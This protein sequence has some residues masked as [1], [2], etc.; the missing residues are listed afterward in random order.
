MSLSLT[1]SLSFSLSLTHSLSLS[2]SLSLSPLPLA[3]CL[4]SYVVS[5]CVA[6]S[7]FLL[8]YPCLALTDRATPGQWPRDG[9][10]RHI[11]YSTQRA[12]TSRQVTPGT[13][14]PPPRAGRTS[15]LP[16]TGHRLPPHPAPAPAHAC[17]LQTSAPAQARAISAA[18]EGRGDR[19]R[20][21]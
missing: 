6:Y 16:D 17:A 14:P 9:A 20:T 5:C 7:G 15:R 11:L 13:G 4:I 3:S 21:P 8:F 19:L 2:L 18:V 12:I 10:E 1:L